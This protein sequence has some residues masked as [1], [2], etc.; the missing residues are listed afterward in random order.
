MEIIKCDD[1]ILKI[2]DVVKCHCGKNIKI[3]TIDYFTG[4]EGMLLFPHN[5]KFTKVEICKDKHT[6]HS[7]DK[8][9]LYLEKY[10]IIDIENDTLCIYDN[11]LFDIYPVNISDYKD[12]I[13]KLLDEDKITYVEIICYNNMHKI[14]DL[15]NCINET[16]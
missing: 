15:F 4:Q 5:Y 11:K 7:E 9:I 12:K 10:Q 2:K 3:K 16:I 1:K 13:Q 8:H 6:L 14:Y